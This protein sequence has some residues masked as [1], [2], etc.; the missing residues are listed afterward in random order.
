MKPRRSKREI[1]LDALT[2][3]GAEPEAGITHLFYKVGVSWLDA[4]MLIAQ[5]TERGLIEQRGIGARFVYTLTPKGVEVI[6]KWIDLLAVLE[7]RIPELKPR[8]W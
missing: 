7:P 1:T 5:L 4:K 2:T 3:I 6:K 8:T